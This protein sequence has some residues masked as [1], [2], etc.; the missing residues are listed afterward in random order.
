ME[1]LRVHEAEQLQEAS[2]LDL[3]FVFLKIGVTSF[4][5]ASRPMM[6]REAVERHRW[7]RE[8]DFLAG[9]A[10]AQV[11]PGANPVNLA[12]YIGLRARGAIGATIAVVGMVVPAFC[13][14]LAMGIGYRELTGF[15]A[16]HMVLAG[17]AAAGVAAT[18]ATGL[19]MAVRLE[20]HVITYVI[21]GAVFLLVG[22]LRWPMVPVVAVGIPLSFAL[23]WFT[24]KGPKGGPKTH[25]R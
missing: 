11:L 23:A 15:S 22:I 25:G 7:L 21:M 3:I 5:G 20:R 1:G 16:T 10:I 6:H 2:L 14:I 9:F 19:K 17:L 4:G 24:D 12:L 13:I 18:L 8:Q